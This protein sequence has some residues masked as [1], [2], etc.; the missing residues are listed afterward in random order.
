VVYGEPITTLDVSQ[1]ARLNALAG[2]GKTPTGSKEVLEELIN[3]KLKVREA[4][5]FGITVSDAEVEETFAQM[6]GRMRL[7]PEQLSEQMSRSGTSANAIKSRVRADLVWQRLVR[8]RFSSTLSVGER[9]VLSAVQAKSLGEG[10]TENSETAARDNVAY[11][12]SLT[13]VLLVAPE[14][15]GAIEARRREAQALRDRFLNCATGLPATRT[16]RDVAIRDK[17]VRTSSDMPAALRKIL[18]GTPVG[19]L[20]P[21]E[22]TKYGIEMFAVCEKVQVQADSPQ[23]REAR[24]ALFAQKFDAQSKRYLQRLR[25]SALIEYK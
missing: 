4:A 3:D 17:V 1:R 23:K 14:G 10:D 19:R 8:G 2:G 7:K 15:S 11:E 16:M 6:A 20:T 22:T 21:P 18:D 12:Y 5:R 24:E 13:P 9:D 25:R